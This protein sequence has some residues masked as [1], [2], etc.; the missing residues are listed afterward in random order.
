MTSGPQRSSIGR[1]R[2]GRLG[3]D[4]WTLD[5]IVE[6]EE[7]PG[8]RDALELVGA[9]IDED[10]IRAVHQAA[11]DAGQEDLARSGRRSDSGAEVDGQARDISSA[12]VHLAGV[13]SLSAHLA[14]AG[15]RLISKQSRFVFHGL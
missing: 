11:Y 8:V 5:V 9:L 2:V 10:E 12:P 13:Q 7:V 3:G 15:G 4:D 1:G 6:C 14:Q